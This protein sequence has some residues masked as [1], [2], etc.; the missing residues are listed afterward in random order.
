M[1]G[2]SY[3]SLVRI[4]L[5]QWGVGGTQAIKNVLALV[6]PIAFRFRYSRLTSIIHWSYFHKI[7]RSSDLVQLGFNS[8]D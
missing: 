8:V 6:R 4:M 1:I 7:S 3:S 2:T 5:L